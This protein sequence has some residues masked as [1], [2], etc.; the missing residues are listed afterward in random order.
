MTPYEAALRLLY[1]EKTFLRKALDRAEKKPNVTA[2]EI[3]RLK[4]KQA[5]VEYLLDMMGGVIVNE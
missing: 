2:E 5:G 3:E 1:R 4:E